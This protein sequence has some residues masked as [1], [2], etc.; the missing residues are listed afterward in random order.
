MKRSIPQ[1]LVHPNSNRR[2]NNPGPPSGFA[3]AVNGTLPRRAIGLALPMPTVAARLQI[4]P[5]NTAVVELSTAWKWRWYYIF[6]TSLPD[7]NVE[8]WRRTRSRARR[9]QVE[10][11]FFGRSLRGFYVVTAFDIRLV[12]GNSRCISFH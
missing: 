8:M 6:S 10:S 7:R 5:C 4:A 1:T 12:L 2:R 9:K 11:R 3:N